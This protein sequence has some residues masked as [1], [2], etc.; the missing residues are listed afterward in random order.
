MTPQQKKCSIPLRTSKS[1][2]K[3]EKDFGLIAEIMNRYLS[4][5][6]VNQRVSTKEFAEKYFDKLVTKAIDNGE[7]VIFPHNL[8]YMQV[9]EHRYEPIPQISL[10]K[11]KAHMLEFGDVDYSLVWVRHPMF[12]HHKIKIGNVLNDRVKAN[13]RSGMKFLNEYT[14]GDT[15]VK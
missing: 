15:Y 13:K 10:A 11:R 4:K 12:I 6:K 7:R 1:F 14:D 2:Y 8:G 5:W 3:S 9:L